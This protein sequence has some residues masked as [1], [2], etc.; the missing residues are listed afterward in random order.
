MEGKVIMFENYRTVGKNSRKNIEIAVEKRKRP[1]VLG[2]FPDSMTSK[3]SRVAL[4]KML[5][6]K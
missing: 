4:N 2:D 6:L 1:V 5:I 3:N